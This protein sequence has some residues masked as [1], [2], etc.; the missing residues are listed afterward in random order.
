M[1]LSAY[2]FVSPST[3]PDNALVV[4]FLWPLLRLLWEGCRQVNFFDEE[5]S[6]SHSDIQALMSNY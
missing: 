4:H 6:E 3:S 2:Y 1:V 5:E